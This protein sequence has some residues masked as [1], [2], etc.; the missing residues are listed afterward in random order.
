[1]AR[2]DVPDLTDYR[3]HRAVDAAEFEGVA[4][5]GLS[6]RFLRRV[7]TGRVESIACY[8]HRGQE[9]LLAW[10]FVDEAHC[11]W[12]SV[13]VDGEWQ[14]PRAGCPEV[15]VFKEGQR[16]VGFAVRDGRGTWLGDALPTEPDAP[17][18]QAQSLAA[19]SEPLPAG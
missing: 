4:V 9:L 2:V 19:R 1:M 6:V 13:H 14:E 10:G 5:P 7:H 8:R 17:V 18:A 12:H 16:V 15:R 11:R 3:I